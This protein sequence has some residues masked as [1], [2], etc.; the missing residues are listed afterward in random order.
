MDMVFS[1]LISQNPDLRNPPT[2]TTF[3]DTADIWS[4][5]LPDAGEGNDTPFQYSCLENPMDGEAW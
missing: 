1:V 2:V 4:G 3:S 5:L